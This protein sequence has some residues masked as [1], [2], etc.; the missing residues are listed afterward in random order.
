[1]V[2]E[3]IS[4]EP[5]RPA[6]AFVRQAADV[7]ADVAIATTS[8][9]ELGE[10]LDRVAQVTMDAT[11]A[12]RVSLFLLDADHRSLRLW[13]AGSRIPNEELWHRSVPMPPIQLDEVPARRLLLDL[14][15]PFC[16]E[17]ARR[18]PL[19]PPEWADAFELESLILAPLRHGDDTVGLLVADY[20]SRQELSPELI[21]LVG[22]IARSTA[23]TVGNVRLTA[24]LAERAEAV[25]SILDASIA[26]LSS[27]SVTEV[28]DEVADA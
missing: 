25:Q 3:A 5:A 14:G 20:H 11:G 18:S 13:A 10:V 27:R 26:L 23:L 28:A 16:I 6:T 9:N 2:V 12:D 19:V 24:A 17:D 7:L 8:G 15:E 22:L 1:M 4:A 21:Q